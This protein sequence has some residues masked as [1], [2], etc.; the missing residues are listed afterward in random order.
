MK[1]N[2]FPKLEEYWFMQDHDELRAAAA[3]CILNLL[4]TK[5]V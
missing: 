1:E 5:E 4:H 3:E 2:V